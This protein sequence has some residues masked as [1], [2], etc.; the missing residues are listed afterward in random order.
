MA[1]SVGIVLRKLHTHG[2]TER[3]TRELIRGLLAAGHHVHLFAEEWDAEL[4]A[5]LTCHRIHTIKAARWLKAWSFAWLAA[6][7]TQREKLD[8]VHSQARTYADDVAT[9]GGGCHADYLE[10]VTAD[11]SPRRQQ[12]ERNHPFNRVVLALEAAQYRNCTRLIL[13][14]H[15]AKAGLVR[16][17]PGV[18][19]KCRVI[20]NGIDADFFAPHA[21][22][23]A[24]LR[25]ELGVGEE[26]VVF[27]F[28]GSGFERKGLAQFLQAFAQ[29][30]KASNNANMLALI[31]GNGDFPHYRALAEQLAITDKVHF[32]GETKDTRPFYCAGDVFVLPTKFDPFANTTNEALAAGLPV[33]TTRSNGGSEVVS[34][35]VGFVVE[36]ADAVDAMADAMQKLLNSSL[37]HDMAMA[38]R[39]NALTRPWS[40]VTAKTL[41]VYDEIMKERKKETSI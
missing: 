36:S 1:L 29:T 10:R 12:W 7:A 21:E 9:L 15:L 25:K 22:S 35:D 6:R 20:H 23:R 13:N 3:R 16:Y 2:G 31:V 27:L 24:Q 11:L 37:R 39:Q 38:A 26:T 17:F 28:V 4:G 14:S 34:T 18:E 40:Q 33:I 41:S 8:I 32:A 5:D 30:H 19:D